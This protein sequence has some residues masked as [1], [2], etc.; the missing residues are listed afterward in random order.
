VI[1]DFSR[2]KSNDRSCS[3]IDTPI[4]PTQNTPP[5]PYMSTYPPVMGPVFLSTLGIPVA[6]SRSH[7]W[8]EVAL[9]Y[10]LCL[11]FHFFSRL[12][13]RAAFL[14]GSFSHSLCEAFTQLQPEK[15]D[16]RLCVGLLYL[17]SFCVCCFVA[18]LHVFVFVVT[19]EYPKVYPILIIIRSWY[20]WR[21]Y[22]PLIPI[23]LPYWDS[24]K[25]PLG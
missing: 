14:M 2:P 17:Q 20:L 8:M 4:I 19:V 9:A 24:D 18:L 11:S 22:Q 10:L 23:V 5:K 16:S 3:A 25:R 15:Q 13:P 6:F 1:D 21:E 7:I 12:I